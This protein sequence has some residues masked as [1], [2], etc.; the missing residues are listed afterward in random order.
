MKK[1][2]HSAGS[3]FQNAQPDL[4]DHECR[5][6]EHRPYPRFI[7]GADRDVSAVTALLYRCSVDG[8]SSRSCREVV[9]FSDRHGDALAALTWLREA[10]RCR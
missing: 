1:A 9:S 4:T 7:D 10:R 2:A 6:S 5:L 3:Q 8:W